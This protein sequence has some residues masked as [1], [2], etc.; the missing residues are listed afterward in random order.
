M[1]QRWPRKSIA[2]GN[3]VVA[4]PLS[5]ENSEIFNHSLGIEEK[6]IDSHSLGTYRGFEVALRCDK[7]G[8]RHIGCL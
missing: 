8:A 5:T 3:M 1:N 6:G 4:V 7:A 2:A